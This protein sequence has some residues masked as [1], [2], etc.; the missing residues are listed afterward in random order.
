MLCICCFV[1]SSCEQDDIIG[2]APYCFEQCEELGEN[3]YLFTSMYEVSFNQLTPITSSDVAQKHFTADELQQGPDVYV[4]KSGSYT[5]T[6]TQRD[7]FSFVVKFECGKYP[8][9]Y[10]RYC[11]MFKTSVKG[12]VGVLDFSYDHG[13]WKELHWHAHL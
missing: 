10:P 4:L 12:L 7:R 3:E 11:F 5:V 6:I 2:N 9:S 8:P 1:F 13:I